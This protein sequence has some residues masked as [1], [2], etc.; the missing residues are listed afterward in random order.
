MLGFT[1][2]QSRTLHLTWIAF[3]LTFLAWFNM[4]PFN[5]TIMQ[6]LELTEAEIKILMIC[7]VVLTIPARI[8]IGSLTDQH[9]PQKVFSGLLLFAGAVCVSFSFSQSFEG[10]LI[11]RLLMGIVGGGFVVGI[12]MIADWFPQNKMGT[13][14]GI[15]AGWGNF[16]AAAASFSLPLIAIPFSISIGW[17]VAIAVSGIL[18]I[19]WAFV[20]FRFCPDIPE[21]NQDFQVGLH[22]TLEVHSKK[23]MILQSLVLFPLY[24]ALMLFV[25]K[26]TG[27]PLNLIPSSISWALITG[28]T[29]V[30]ISN[31]IQC[32]KL[33]LPRI[34]KSGIENKTYPFSQV[35][36]L[37]LIYSLTFGSELAVISIFPQFLK[38]TFSI[39]VGLAG[40]LGASYAFMNLI[41]RPGGGWVSD[42]FGR[43]KTLSL[44]IL[45]GLV[46]HWLIG[47]INSHWPLY[48]VII[49]SLVGSMFF[50]AGNGACFA[51]IPL[52]SKNLTG[53]MAGLAG[54]YGSVGAVGFLTLY[55]FVS[56][57][58]FFK[59]IAVYAFLVFLSLFFLK[60]FRETSP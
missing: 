41:S 47:D 7:N 54:A 30:F 51:A 23:D 14:Q 45:G 15:Y 8:V 42:H 56:P 22:G 55:S 6:H 58:E 52:I 10:L 5:T 33:N 44:L 34:K 48:S 4:A 11:N 27:H 20:Y 38:S 35:A 49:L 13:A 39:S 17:R 25:W 19:F 50:Q 29:G 40:I 24:G 26:L 60:P 21:K 3:F 59:I 1:E 18:C 9:G 28:L 37:S 2:T 46:T 36:I 57:Q 53:K 43:R 12:K 32:W 31:L 16:G